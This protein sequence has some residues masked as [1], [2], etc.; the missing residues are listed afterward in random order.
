MAA[1]NSNN[2]QGSGARKELTVSD[3][4]MDTVMR[5]LDRGLSKAH[6]TTLETVIAARLMAVSGAAQMAQDNPQADRLKLIEGIVGDLHRALMQR[7]M[8]ELALAQKGEA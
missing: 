8:P 3:Q 1:D 7:L 5:H 6:A 4:R 2:R